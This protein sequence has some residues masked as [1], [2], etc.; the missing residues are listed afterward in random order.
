MLVAR[1]VFRKKQWNSI[2]AS[3]YVWSSLH[4]SD[5]ELITRAS[6]LKG[7][8][9]PQKMSAWTGHPDIQKPPRRKPPQQKS[10]QKVSGEKEG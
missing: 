6:S 7:A 8:N 10:L 1:R 2:E 5:G 9:V 3:I 4:Q